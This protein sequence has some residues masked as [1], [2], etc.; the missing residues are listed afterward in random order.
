MLPS[1]IRADRGANCGRNQSRCKGVQEGLLARNAPS[2]L[3]TAECRMPVESIQDPT[4]CA[5][6]PTHSPHVSERSCF[7]KCRRWCETHK[8]P[9]HLLAGGGHINSRAPER[10]CLQG[11]PA[12]Q[13]HKPCPESVSLL[14]IRGMCMAQLKL[15]VVGKKA[16][17]R[18]C[19]TA[20]AKPKRLFFLR[21]ESAASRS[22]LCEARILRHCDHQHRTAPETCFL[23]ALTHTQSDTL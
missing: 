7:A 21:R 8:L 6:H 23:F 22:G 12:Q 2:T 1:A 4:I 17:E 15:R 16:V 19:R 3:P 9:P 20:R 18:Q 13:T 5:F 10:V 14:G 11:W